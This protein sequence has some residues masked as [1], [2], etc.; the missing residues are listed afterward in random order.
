MYHL[1]KQRLW[2]E[3]SGA[4]CKKFHLHADLSGL[5]HPLTLIERLDMKCHGL[6]HVG[7]NLG[8][9]FDSYRRA[10]LAYVVYIEPIPEI[11]TALKERV[12][13]DPRHHAIQALCTD[14]SGEEYE[15]N[16]ASNAGESSSI[17]A[18]GNHSEKYPDIE[19]KSKIKLRSTTLDDVIF[20]A[21]MLSSE[22]LD[23]LVMDV[24]GAEM[25]VIQGAH[26]T[27]SRCR[28]VF[29]EISEGGLYAGDSPYEEI[30]A[31][32]KPY[33]FVL[34]SLDLNQQGWGNAFLVKADLGDADRR[35]PL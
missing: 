24:Q 25:K 35:F 6:I 8:Q 34:R 12:S 5:S 10:D 2:I 16:V 20:G 21:N 7:A 22:K 15:F 3:L 30:I 1:I 32:L 31:A 23:C 19:Y 17:F 18:L 26:R 27:L 11:F 29:T 28:Y 4:A 13:V 14:R 9:E 33:G